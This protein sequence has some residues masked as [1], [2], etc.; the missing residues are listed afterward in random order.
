MAPSSNSWLP[1]LVTSSS[2][3]FSASMVGSS[4]KRPEISG[5]AP[6]MSP[7][8][9]VIENLLL[10]LRASRRCVARY[11]TPPA[12]I[13]VVVPSSCSSVTRP[14]EPAGGSRLPCRSLND[15]SCTSWYRDLFLPGLCDGASP[16]LAGIAAASAPTVARPAAAA[17]IRLRRPLRRCAW[18]VA[19]MCPPGFVR[20]KENVRTGP[21]G[22]KRRVNARSATG[23]SWLRPGCRQGGVR[24]KR[25][26]WGRR[27]PTS[28]ASWRG[29]G[30]HIQAAAEPLPRR[31]HATTGS[32]GARG[33]PPGPP[34]G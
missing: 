25:H 30:S 12:L 20:S 26:V 28:S 16:A 3:P 14:E 29:A 31:C 2:S 17:R 21:V 33:H 1:T 15:S 19:D 8:A 9:A 13:V 5:E 32:N 11:S 7:A 22:P 23:G 24:T 6:T 18:G 27:M 4:W 10:A 34:R